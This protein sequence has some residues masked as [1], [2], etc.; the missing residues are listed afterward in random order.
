MRDVFTEIVHYQKM[1]GLEIGDGG[2]PL[3][4]AHPITRESKKW[5]LAK[6]NLKHGT[7]GNLKIRYRLLIKIT[8]LLHH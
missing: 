3:C 6:W 4:Q 1:C 8:N 5:C 2:S 7:I